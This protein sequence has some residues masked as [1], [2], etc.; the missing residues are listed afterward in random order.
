MTIRDVRNLSEHE[1]EDYYEPVRGR[2]FFW[3]IITLNINVMVMEIKHYH[4]KNILITLEHT[5]KNHK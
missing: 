4:L 3:A 5:L 1:E 2:N